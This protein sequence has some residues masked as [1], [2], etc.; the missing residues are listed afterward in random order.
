MSQSLKTS[1]GAP[2]TQIAQICDGWGQ[3][4][5]VKHRD[6]SK[7]GEPNATKIRIPTINLS[8]SRERMCHAGHKSIHT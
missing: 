7:S 6:N 8:P 1:T 2:L 4:H 3:K 5:R